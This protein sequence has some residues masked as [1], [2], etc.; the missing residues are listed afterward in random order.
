MVA[1]EPTVAHA[2]H[3]EKMRLHGPRDYILSTYVAIHKH[4]VRG[5]LDW[6]M[7]RRLD[8]ALDIT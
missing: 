2:C 5:T 1:Q 7:E 6:N 4:T 8:Y 3:E